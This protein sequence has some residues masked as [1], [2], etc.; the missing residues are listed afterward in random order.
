MFL[1]GAALAARGADGADPN[2]VAVKSD[3]GIVAMC[4]TLLLGVV[5]GAA[6]LRRRMVIGM[7]KWIVSC[8]DSM[9]TKVDQGAQVG[10]DD[11]DGNFNVPQTGRLMT[12]SIAS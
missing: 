12:P 4:L 3:L 2:A 11:E 7:L 9:K 5:I 10:P 8:L 6:L 1:S